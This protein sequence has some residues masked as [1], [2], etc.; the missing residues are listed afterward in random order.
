MWYPAFTIVQMIWVEGYFRIGQ[1][2]AKI[3]CH[4]YFLSDTSQKEVIMENLQ[5]KYGGDVHVH[6]NTWTGLASIIQ[7]MHYLILG[8]CF[9]FCVKSKN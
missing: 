1:D 9:K 5:T 8:D 4:H 3:W 7:A 6:E 2:D